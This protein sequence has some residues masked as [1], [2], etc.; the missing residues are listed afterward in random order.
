MPS[1]AISPAW[2]SDVA[3]RLKFQ[4]IVEG[5]A[6]HF[7]EAG[8]DGL[9]GAEAGCKRVIERLDFA[10]TNHPLQLRHTETADVVVHVVEPLTAYALQDEVA[11]QPHFLTKT[12]ATEGAVLP[13]LFVVL[14]PEVD[15]LEA[16]QI[17][18]VEVLLLMLLA[19]CPL[20]LAHLL[21]DGMRQLQCQRLQRAEHEIEVQHCEEHNINGEQGQVVEDGDVRVEDHR[22]THCDAVANQVA[23]HICM[24][25]H[26]VRKAEDVHNIVDAQHKSTQPHQD[27]TAQDV[28]HQ[29]LCRVD[30]NNPTAQKNCSD[31]DGKQHQDR[32]GIKPHTLPLQEAGHGN[33]QRIDALQVACTQQRHKHSRM[34][35]ARLTLCNGM[36]EKR[37]HK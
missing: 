20:L 4:I 19:S 5:D 26:A 27:V 31:V 15:A 34:Q 23:R 33:V 28:F 21:D 16:M 29:L 14:H 7:Q 3:R 30:I 24:L 37:R 18:L 2:F 35:D 17:R 8:T 11:V 10:A 22:Q 9:S 32:S 13:L 25:C 12:V 1:L 36:A 6:F